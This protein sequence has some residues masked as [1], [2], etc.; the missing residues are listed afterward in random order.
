MTTITRVSFTKHAGGNRATATFLLDS[1]EPVERS[2][3][4]AGVDEA[5][6]LVK[7]TAMIPDVEASIQKRDA[8]EA[9]SRGLYTAYGTASEA[10]VQYSW[11][12][13]GYAQEEHYQAYAMIKDLAPALLAMGL[14]DEQYATAFNATTE[15]I[16][17]IR[18]Y[19]EFLS[20]N[21]VA[22]EAYALIAGVEK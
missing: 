16:A 19:W 10:Q 21:S 13:Q 7:A 4:N 17:N 1:G 22:I 15:E 6:A 12:K 9:V 18:T 8:S 5:A 11:L 20:A 14:T 2:I 3:R